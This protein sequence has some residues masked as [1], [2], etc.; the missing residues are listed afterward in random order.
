MLSMAE[1][2]SLSKY[3]LM[4]YVYSDS[5]QSLLILMLKLSFL[6]HVLPEDNPALE[7][8]NYLAHCQMLGRVIEFSI[9]LLIQC[10]KHSP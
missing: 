5:S 10:V 9:S 6:W 4:S 3:T 2:D 1:C 8:Y 7:F